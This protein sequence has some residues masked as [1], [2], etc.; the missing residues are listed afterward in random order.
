[1]IIE[2][3]NLVYDKEGNPLRVIRT[4]KVFFKNRKEEGYVLHIEKAEKVTSI[5]EFDL[6]LI[7]GKYM[8]NKDIFQNTD[9]I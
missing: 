4:S 1:M 3:P 7:N 6:K 9:I 2:I 5:S 8:I